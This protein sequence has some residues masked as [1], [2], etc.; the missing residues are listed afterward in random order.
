METICNY[1]TNTNILI[2]IGAYKG[3]FSKTANSFFPF[4][5]TICFEPNKLLIDVIKKIIVILM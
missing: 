3:L 2:D 4:E 1:L 5:R